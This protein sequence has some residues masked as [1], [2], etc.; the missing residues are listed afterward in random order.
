LSFLND[1]KA[2]LAI[3]LL[4]QEGS[5]WTIVNTF[6][7]AANEGV[8]SARGMANTERKFGVAIRD[9]WNNRS[10]TLVMILTP[11][12]EQEIP[13]NWSA[14]QLPTDS[15]QTAGTMYNLAYLWDGK[16][17]K[18]VGI[19][20]GANLSVLPNWFTIDLKKKV[21]ISRIRMHHQ[22]SD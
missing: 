18:F 11:F 22:E 10:D 16:K 8:F 15:W 6:Y 20:A 3:E 21:V 4:I 9:R 2:S 1:T 17:D 13:K 12:F 19:F 5:D 14:V 7:T